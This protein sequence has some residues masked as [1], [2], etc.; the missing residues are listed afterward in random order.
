[1][2]RTLSVLLYCRKLFL[3]PCS[4]F[5]DVIITVF[6]YVV[7]MFITMLFGGYALMFKLV[8][9]L[10]TLLNITFDPFN[11]PKYQGPP[12]DVPRK[13]VTKEMQYN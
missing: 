8:I 11:A 9:S 10:R 5:S 4:F 12:Y 3:C 7:I 2:C 6:S 1:M 13:S